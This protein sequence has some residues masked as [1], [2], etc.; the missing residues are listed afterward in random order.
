MKILTPNGSLSPIP[1]P[2]ES[3]S[4]PTR[5][6]DP[7]KLT[8]P[9]AQKTKR[10]SHSKKHDLKKLD[11]GWNDAI[12]ELQKKRTDIKT[13]YRSGGPLV[14]LAALQSTG[15]RP[16]ELESGLVFRVKGQEVEIEIKGSKTIKDEEGEPVRGIERRFITINPAFCK[17]SEFLKEFIIKRLHGNRTKSYSFRYNKETFRSVMETL[18]DKYNEIYRKRKTRISITGY[19][20]RHH[21]AASLKAC[22]ELTD[23]ERASVMGHLSVASLQSYASAYRSKSKV[24]PVLRV[25]TSA[26]PKS[27]PASRYLSQTR[28]NQSSS[29]PHHQ[30][31]CQRQL[32]FDPPGRRTKSWTTSG[33]SP[34]IH[35]KNALKRC[36]FF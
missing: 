31:D 4:Q 17:A 10:G 7:E 6:L 22:K 16:D 3:N 14:A 19:F 2:G 27:A 11:A 35:T 15:M 26:A 28:A 20:F 29:T 23:L 12:F 13:L 21:M 24:K 33:T 1:V 18:S 32:N 8:E 25:S 9:R 34:S 5:S 30:S 36:N